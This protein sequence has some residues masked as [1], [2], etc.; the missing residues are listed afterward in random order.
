MFDRFS[1][2]AKRTMMQAREH[3]LQL[4]HD[5]IGP[6][7]LLL[8]ILHVEPSGAA[9]LLRH[10]KVDPRG[11]ETE[12]RLLVTPGARP[13]D[14]Q[15]PF[16]PQAKRVLEMTLVQASELG[17]AVIRTE[18]VLLALAVVDGTVAQQALLRLHVDAR[19]LRAALDSTPTVHDPERLRLL[20][21]SNSTMH[22]GGYLEHC[23][24]EIRD[25]LG[26]K[27]KVLF[28][29]YA[30]ADH[31]GYAA[32]AAQAFA[33]LGHGLISAHQFSER[34]ELAAV[35]PQMD[36]V[37]LG[38]GNTF[39]LL[40]ALHDHSLLAAIRN[41]ALAGMPLIGSSAGTNVATLS[42]RTTN[43]MPIV[44][45]PSFAALQLVPF[46]INPHYLDPDPTSKHMGETR[47]E[48]IRQF[49]E[50]DAA[51]VLG[52]REGCM[53]RVEGTRMTLR[54]T[55]AARLFRRGQAPEEFSPP[56]DLSFLL[57][58]AAEPGKS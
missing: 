1:D 27:K 53:L 33:A 40:K 46:Q 34:A 15:L 32:K 45:P 14:G 35:L 57:T 2:N 49:H 17:A 55:T 6:E 44:M 38:G 52:L 41:R 8:G 25:F 30:L 3:A 18:H 23:A 10:L 9:Q 19:K 20:L 16:T 37:F 13:A 28:I 50:E 24:A 11:I 4:G 56:C 36:A 54:G 43:D 5:F 29:P 26:D 21:I 7:H 39:R 22:G 31:D 51:P 12:V 47:E 42:I 58:K 48:R